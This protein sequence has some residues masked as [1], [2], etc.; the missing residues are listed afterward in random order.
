[1]DILMKN[2]WMK[3]RK[4]FET[5]NELMISMEERLDCMLNALSLNSIWMEI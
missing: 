5:G 3:L 2:F 1:M 4:W